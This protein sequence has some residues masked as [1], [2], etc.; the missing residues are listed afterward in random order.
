M[1]YVF[2]F[3]KETKYMF[4]NSNLLVPSDKESEKNYFSE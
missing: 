4:G 2:F 3:S 1:F